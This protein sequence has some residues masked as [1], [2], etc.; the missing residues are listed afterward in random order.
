MIIYVQ[1]LNEGT[2]VF[3]PVQAERIDKSTARLLPIADYDSSGETW[4]FPPGS[5][6][7]YE[8]RMLEGEMVLVAIAKSGA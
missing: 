8:D 1:L 7:R 5:V 2:V 6:V 3:R 4:E